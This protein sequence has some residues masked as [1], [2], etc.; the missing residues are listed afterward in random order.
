M[1]WSFQRITP[2]FDERREIERLHGDDELLKLQ[3]VGSVWF[4]ACR[5]TRDLFSEYTPDEDGTVTF[6]SVILTKREQGEWGYK[7]MGETSGPNP[8]YCRCPMSI[9]ALGSKV[10]PGSYADEFR[11]RCRAWARRP[12]PKLH[13]VW[14]LAEPV[15]INGQPIDT[16]K[17]VTNRRMVFDTQEVGLIRLSGEHLVNAVK[18]SGGG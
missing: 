15:H 8:G 14:R 2:W 12:K 11:A 13:E 7:A 4:S 10:E 5:T 17:R 6:I 3:K 9:I 16:V 18:L 1:G